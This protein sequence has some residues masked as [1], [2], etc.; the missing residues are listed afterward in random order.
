MNKN[1][2]EIVI[3]RFD[4]CLYY[5][6]EE[7]KDKE[8][9]FKSIVSVPEYNTI[10]K[11]GDGYVVTNRFDPRCNDQLTPLTPGYTRYGQ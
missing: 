8:E 7:A 9:E 10:E 3:Q 2:N 5:T 6:I 4:S 1:S 11:Y